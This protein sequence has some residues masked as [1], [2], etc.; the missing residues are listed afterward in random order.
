MA[1]SPGR[2][3]LQLLLSTCAA[4]QNEVH[5]L[6]HCQDCLCALLE[7][8]F[9]QEHPSLFA[10]LFLWRPTW[11]EKPHHQKRRKQSVRIRRVAGKKASRPLLI[12]LKVR[13]MLKRAP[14]L[15]SALNPALAMTRGLDVQLWVGLMEIKGHFVSQNVIA[16]LVPWVIR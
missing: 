14:G 16:F 10:R 13:R 15:F 2:P 8:N 11:E 5:V 6:L 9:S 7:R 4:V 12:G 3:V 1:A